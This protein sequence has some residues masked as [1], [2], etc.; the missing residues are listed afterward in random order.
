[1]ITKDKSNDENHSKAHMD[2]LTASDDAHRQ[3]MKKIV[4]IREADSVHIK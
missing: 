1:M 3:A 4:E 2:A